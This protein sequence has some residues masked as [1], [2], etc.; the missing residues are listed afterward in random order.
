MPATSFNS[1]G[2]ETFQMYKLDSEM[3]E[4]TEIK[5]PTSV[6]HRNSKGIPEKYLLRLH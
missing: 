3:A 4:E 6:G 1:T 5:S 2:T